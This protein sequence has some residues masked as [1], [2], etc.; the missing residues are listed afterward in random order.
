M[1]LP[2]QRQIFLDEITHFMLTHD[3]SGASGSGREMVGQ[4][5]DVIDKTLDKAQVQTVRIADAAEAK[6]FSNEIAEILAA[7]HVDSALVTDLSTID[8]FLDDDIVEGMMTTD[9][10]GELLGVPVHPDDLFI[11]VAARMRLARQKSDE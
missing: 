6:V 7:L 3:F 2:H 5:I 11:D 4:L 1:L 10:L 8:T 9:H